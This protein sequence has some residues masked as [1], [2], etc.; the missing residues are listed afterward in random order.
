M[1]ILIQAIKE[2]LTYN[3]LTGIVGSRVRPNGNNIGSNGYIN[4][5]ILGKDIPAHHIAFV[6]M[7]GELPKLE[8][9]H[10]NRIRH[11]NRWSNLRD[12]TKSVN[13]QNKGIQKNNTTGH[14]GISFDGRI[15]KYIAQIET[16][17]NGKR[18]THRT[19]CNSLEEAI[20]EREQ[21]VAKYRRKPTSRSES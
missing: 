19:S 4:Y 18:K 1:K 17:T 6:F 21:L 14:T 7:T 3:P 10:K 15:N 11:D 2:N 9:D 20:H 12:V 16:R 5:R 13:M 8:V